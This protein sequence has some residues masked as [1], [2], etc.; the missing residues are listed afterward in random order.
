M[1]LFPK[2]GSLYIIYI[3]LIFKRIY[4]Q[5]NSLP[6]RAFKVIAKFKKLKQTNMKTFRLSLHLQFIF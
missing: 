1:H 2:N 3:N 5:N 4:L 6:C